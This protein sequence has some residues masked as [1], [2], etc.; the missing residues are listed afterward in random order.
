MVLPPDDGV[1]G[2]TDGFDDDVGDTDGSVPDASGEATGCACTQHGEHGTAA[3][4][5][6][7]VP[8]LA[9]RRRRSSSTADSRRRGS[10]RST[11]V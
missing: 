6:A 1:P 10:L 9:R 2:E 8:W 11:R 7:W 3:L 4:W 5:L